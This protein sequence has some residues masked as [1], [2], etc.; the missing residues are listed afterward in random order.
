MSIINYAVEIITEKTAFTNNAYG[1]QSGIFRYITGQPGYDGNDNPYPTNEDGTDN[2]EIWYEGW[3]L[4]NKMNNPN[5]YVDITETGDY[6]TISGFNFSIRNDLV[7]WKY[8]YDNNIFFTNR[9][10]RL[11]C[12]I[13]DVF[14]QI[15]TGVIANNPYDEVDY[16]FVCQDQ[17]KKVHKMMP[18]QVIYK[19]LNPDAS[20]KAQGETIPISIG[21]V[22]YSKL[23]VITDEPIVED[24]VLSHRTTD[25]TYYAKACGCAHY[26][27]SDLTYPKLTLFTQLI[28]F[29][30]DALVNKYIYVARGGGEPDT[31]QLIKIMGNEATAGHI[32]IVEIQAPFD[33]I[34]EDLFNQKY[35]YDPFG[36]S[37]GDKIYGYYAYDSYDCI[38]DTW[39][40]YQIKNGSWI[41]FHDVD[42]SN[43]TYGCNMIKI[44]FKSDHQGLVKIRLGSET[45]DVIGQGIIEA[46]SYKH[47]KEHKIEIQKQ[48]GDSE[49]V[50]LTFSDM[51]GGTYF[52]A[53]DYIHIYHNQSNE[54]TWWFSILRM[55]SSHLISN[56]DIEG[57]ETDKTGKV[58]VFVYNDQTGKME[59]APN[60]GLS[61]DITHSGDLGYP[62]MAMYTSRMQKDGNV[63]YMTPIP[64]EYW[65]VEI[66]NKAGYIIRS[67]GHF[68]DWISYRTYQN[69]GFDLGNRDQT[70]Y[71]TLIFP[72][73]ILRNTYH[74]SIKM[75]FPEEHINQEY[76][77][78]YAAFDMNINANGATGMRMFG[79][80]STLDAYGREVETEADEIDPVFYF[81]IDEA[82]TG[83]QMDLN[84]LPEDYYADG[85]SA[86]GMSL[87]GCIAE[88]GNG[89]DVSMKSL[90]E[91]PDFIK[92]SLLDGTTTNQIKLNIYIT[93]VGTGGDNQGLYATVLLKEAGFIGYKS[94]NPLSDDF[95]VRLRGETIDGEES[96]TVYKT[97]K[98]ML[99]TYDGIT[100]TQIDYTNLPYARDSWDCGRQ[101]TD[102]KSSFDY[103]SELARQSFVAVYPTREGK[104]G[105]RAWRDDYYTY[106]GTVGETGAGYVIQEY[107]AYTGAVGGLGEDGAAYEAPIIVDSI[108]EWKNTEVAS[109]FNDFE[110]QFN[111]NP[112]NNKPQDVI[113]VTHADE[114]SYPDSDEEDPVTGLLLWKLYVGGVSGQSYSDALY[115]WTFCNDGYDRANAIQPLNDKLRKLYWYT[116]DNTYKGLT[117]IGVSV[118]SSAYKFTRNCIEWLTR[119]K[120]QVK[121]ATPITS[122]S[123]V[124]DLLRVVVFNDPIYTDSTDRVGWI[125][126]IEVDTKNDKMIFTYL[127][128]PLDLVEDNLIIEDGIY[129]TLGTHTEAG[130]QDDQV[131]DGQ[132]R[133]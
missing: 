80:Y 14:Y 81:P 12:V 40:V 126:G 61:S 124:K 83:L 7:L 44:G 37:Y 74:F 129:K 113:V 79:T 94:I 41:Q 16:Q 118:D 32:T 85:G 121:F 108:V 133:T 56:G 73:T 49:D 23:Q 72:E 77:S 15:W 11:Y 96:N 55:P 107:T 26:Q 5:R 67:D 112:A 54:D 53:L 24:V 27:T 9:E 60:I 42:L 90:L 25:T 71:L 43:G 117:D 51:Q 39:A 64:A 88:D 18:P 99:E 130:D 122:A 38:I 69:I 2:T 87:W 101:L 103:I 31:D 123:V 52:T 22:L 20:E 28:D 127:L 34:T 45:G 63:K 93:S 46:Y 62:E 131:D 119:Q 125:V 50:F 97:F 17:F 68:V 8:I 76:D 33:F 21:N 13:D 75:S 104:R 105:L 132:D 29:E 47:T 36:G 95:Y 86:T 59:I 35:A 91:L 120:A 19:T 84:F 10:I 70:D 114:S 115:L 3:L 78:I 57:F 65:E 1:L 128:E 111:F 82:V 58:Q 66:E 6:G 30:E 110:I 116:N 89:D 98:L 109:L 106:T 102:R 4:K 92:G 48:Y 100:G